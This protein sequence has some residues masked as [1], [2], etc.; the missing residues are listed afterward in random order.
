MPPKK[1]ASNKRTT[2]SDQMISDLMLCRASAIARHGDLSYQAKNASGR[3]KGYMEIMKELWEEK[4]YAS[5]GYTAQ[6]LRDKAAQVLKT[7]ERTFSNSCTNDVNE[8]SVN[9]YSRM[10]SPIWLVI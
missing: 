6:N 10:K 3:R 2:W 1:K 9:Y 4:G 8:T 5:L 7:T